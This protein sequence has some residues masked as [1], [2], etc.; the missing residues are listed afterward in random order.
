MLRTVLITSLVPFWV[1]LREVVYTVSNP[2][3]CTSTSLNK[4]V[5]FEKDIVFKWHLLAHDQ[6]GTRQGSE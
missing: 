4:D 2:V 3:F 6:Q 1:A 5:C